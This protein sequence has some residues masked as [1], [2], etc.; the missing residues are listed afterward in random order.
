MNEQLFTGEQVPRNR[1]KGGHLSPLTCPDNT[2]N[3]SLWMQIQESKQMMLNK[4]YH[5]VKAMEQFN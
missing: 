4:P 2:S 1:L 5:E 3:L